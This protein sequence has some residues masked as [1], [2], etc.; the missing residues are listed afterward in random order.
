MLSQPCSEFQ[1][2]IKESCRRMSKQSGNAL[3]ELAIA[4][5]TMTEPTSATQASLDTSK[6]AIRSLKTALKGVSFETPDLLAI[7][8][9]ATVASV[10]VEVV[11]CVEKISTAVH[12]LSN[13]AHFKTL[14]PLA[15]ELK[16]VFP[17]NSVPN[18]DV[19]LDK[20]IVIKLVPPPMHNETIPNG[21]V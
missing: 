14:E 9:A 5:K 10:L 11:K 13:L 3:R 2:K 21:H 16:H 6:A 15:K 18:D 17:K 8:P 20:I 19:N 7:L 4:I 1:A 12:E